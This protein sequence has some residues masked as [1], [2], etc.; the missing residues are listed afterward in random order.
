MFVL[1]SDGSP[2]TSTKS[3][4]VAAYSYRPFQKLRRSEILLPTY[5]NSFKVLPSAT[6]HTVHPLTC[7]SSPVSSILARRNAPD[8]LSNISPLAKRMRWSS[9]TVAVAV[10]PAYRLSSTSPAARTPRLHKSAKSTAFCSRSPWF[11]FRFAQSL[12]NLIP[13]CGACPHLQCEIGK[14][15]ASLRD[16]LFV[17]SR[18]IVQFHGNG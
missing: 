17:P 16:R 10:T 12:H 8:G 15:G 1:R 7:L 6:F 11:T 13:R 14:S 5:R 9:V 3:G 18:S 4:R 2:Y